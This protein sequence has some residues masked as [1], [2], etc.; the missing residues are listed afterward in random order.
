MIESMSNALR[1]V[2][3]EL[4]LS[5]VDDPVTRTVARKIIELAERGVRETSQLQ[6][7]V[8]DEFNN[9]QLS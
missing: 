5:L 4:G 2:C 9:G 6:A 1:S 8:L 7:M 3:A